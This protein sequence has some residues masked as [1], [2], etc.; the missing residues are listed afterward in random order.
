[1]TLSRPLG[2]VRADHVE[3]PVE[4]QSEL[5]LER[6][7]PAGRPRRRRGRGHGRRPRREGAAVAH[8]AATGPRLVR[9]LSRASTNAGTFQTDRR[10][11]DRRTGLATHSRPD[12]TSTPTWV[13]SNCGQLAGLDQVT[14]AIVPWPRRSSLVVEETTP[15][16]APC[17]RIGQPAVHVGMAGAARR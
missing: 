5:A 9:S 10:H 15:R 3:R 7:A 13:S 6:T 2:R 17:R 1:M 14:S 4:R 12:G 16:S 8:V 11:A